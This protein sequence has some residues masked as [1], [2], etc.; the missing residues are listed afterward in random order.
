M[1]KTRNFV[2]FYKFLTHPCLHYTCI[3]SCICRQEACCQQT[4]NHGGQEAP[5][6]GNGKGSEDN[7]NEGNK[8]ETGQQG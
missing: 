3:S 6:D 4:G 7:N 2:T 1:E 5:A 8:E